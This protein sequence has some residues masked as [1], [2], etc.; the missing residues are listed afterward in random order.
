M[1]FIIFCVYFSAKDSLGNAK[2]VVFSLFCILFAGQWGSYNVPSHFLTIKS[3][4]YPIGIFAYALVWYKSERVYNETDTEV[5]FKGSNSA[6][7]C[8]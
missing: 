1:L 5:C 8:S 7:Y 2:N 3:C 4:P 6:L